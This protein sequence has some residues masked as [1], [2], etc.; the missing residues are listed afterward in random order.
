MGF[1]RLYWV[2]MCSFYGRVGFSE[3]IIINMEDFA[4]ECHSIKCLL[5]KVEENRTELSRV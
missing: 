5:N 3:I 2:G 4:L 1:V